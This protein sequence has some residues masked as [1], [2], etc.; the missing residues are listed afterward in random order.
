MVE[1][2]VLCYGDRPVIP[3]SLRPRGLELVH[4]DTHPGSSSTRN[5]LQTCAWWP[6]YCSDVESFVRRCP[7][8]SKNRSPR[9]STV[10]SWPLE[11]E[12]WA[13]VHMD[14][15]YLPKVGLLLILVDA[16]SGWPEAIRVPNRDASTVKR[17]LQAVFARN[18]IPYVLV[19]DNAAE[20]CDSN[21]VQWLERIGCRTLKTPPMH[22]QS[23][24]IAERMVQTIKKTSKAWNA[25]GGESYDSFLS[26]L[27]LNYRC[28][29]H[30]G[31]IQSPAQ[32]MGRQL[33][34]P[35]S[36]R[37]PI[38]SGMWY[39]PDFRGVREKVRFLGQKGTNTALIEREDGRITLAHTDQ[40]KDAIENEDGNSSLDQS[41]RT[42]PQPEPTHDQP[43]PEPNL[44]D[45]TS[46]QELHEE[47][48]RRYPIRS[49]RGVP[50]DRFGGGE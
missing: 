16:M 14:H 38:D 22:P 30:A 17:V 35:I 29:P 1:E 31:R 37:S 33:R 32:L 42:F 18:G 50:P 28:L 39:T 46:P 20:F 19:S 41:S 49:N 10:H 5:R 3:T 44:Q 40:L 9:Q 7:V 26:R 15:A 23:N 34:N 45:P 2:G 6:G 27:L 25:A 12:P 47:R 21:L 24:G 43:T 11:S 13:R 36:M 48:P 8:C 4:E